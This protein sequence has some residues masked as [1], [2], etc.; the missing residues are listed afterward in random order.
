MRII[1]GKYKQ[2]LL[3]APDGALTRPTSDKARQGVFNILEHAPFADGIID[4]TIIDVFAGSGAMALE[5]LSRGAHSVILV[6]NNK[7]ALAVINHNIIQLNCTD[8]AT[9]IKDDATK[10]RQR[11]NTTEKVDIVFMDPPYKENLAP[12]A[13]SAL[14]AGDW[15]NENA[16]I[17]IEQH[18]SAEAPNIVGFE[19]MKTVNYGING[20]VFLK[21]LALRPE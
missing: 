20:F 5:A 13:I 12:A 17:I 18:K 15:L 11:P 1:S 8:S 2:R 16:I 7:S 6:E 3:V 4:K 21:R 14:L 9:I 10:I 19:I